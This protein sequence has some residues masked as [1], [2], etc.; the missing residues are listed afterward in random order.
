MDLSLEGRTALVSGA[1][2]GIG[3]A[4]AE[5]LAREGCSVH[6]VARTETDLENASRRSQQVAAT[7]VFIHPLDLS[8]S[9]NV[10]QIASTC[11]QV[12]I[13]VNNAGAI[14]GGTMESIDETTWREAW[15]LKLFGYVNLTRHAYANMRERSRGVIIN[16]I[17]V[18]GERPSA[19]YVAG[20]TANAAL[21]ALT[22]ALGGAS[23]RDGIRVVGINPGLIQTERME[24]LMRTNAKAQ[25][26][27]ESRWRELVSQEFPPG[28]PEH[29]ADMVAFLASDLSSNTSG[30]IVT[31]DGGS[32]AR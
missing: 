31:I 5:R 19:G 1:S 3:Y 30:T 20:G 32:S 12:D 4:A 11:A 26:G 8:V 22:R 24:T 13:V 7:E 10:D 25:L 29:I 28:R 21:M 9:A 27:D 23:I 14:P 15:D 16:V 6:L 2:K 17:G 18:A